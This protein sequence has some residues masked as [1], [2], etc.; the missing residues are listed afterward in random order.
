MASG[1]KTSL[2]VA[3]TSDCQQELRSWQ[4]STTIS[5]GLARRGRI[6]LLLSS[7]VSVSDVSRTVGMGRPHVYKW[8]RRFILN[9]ID[10]LRDKT[11]RGRKTGGTTPWTA[12]ERGRW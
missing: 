5:V 12:S 10:G 11:G 4:R 7:G 1:R 6:I 3:L 9:G 2:S 8:A